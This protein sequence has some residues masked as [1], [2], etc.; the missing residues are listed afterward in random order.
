MFPPA[1]R[2]DPR[3]LLMDCRAHDS[4][5]AP[6]L[7]IGLAVEASGAP[8][9]TRELIG[10]LTQIKQFEVALC[11]QSAE[12]GEGMV[13]RRSSWLGEILLDRS[14]RQFD[15]FAPC[16]VN[17]PGITTT[18]GELDVVFCVTPKVPAVTT[19]FGI[20]SLQLGDR[21]IDPPYWGEVIAGD[22]LSRITLRWQANACTPARVVRT[23]DFPTRRGLGFTRNADNCLL[24]AAQMLAET[25][26]SIA[27]LGEEWLARVHS[28]PEADGLPVSRRPGNLECAVFAA[29]EV[30]RSMAKKGKP[31]PKGWFCAIRRDGARAYRR[32]GRFDGSGFEEMP[33][34]A[35]AQMAD[36]F[37][38]SENGRDWLF[39]EDVPP[40]TQKGRI[41][42]VEIPK[43]GQP[44][45]KAEV[46]LECETHLSYPC[47]FRHE[48]EF[49]MIPESCASQDLRLYRATKFP[50]EWQLETLLLENLPVT[51]TTPYFCGEHWYF[52]STT[53]PPV[54]QTVLLTSAKLGGRLRLHPSSPVSC[55]WRNTRAAGHI[56]TM[57]GRL[58]RPTQDCATDYGYGIQMN[59]VTRLSP[60]E[61]AERAADYIGPFWRRGLLGTHTLTASGDLEVIDGR[62]YLQ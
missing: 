60:S 54:Q 10:F 53:L 8:A 21:D 25:A 7:R 45:P 11:P 30:Y 28:L 58:I 4:G 31:R 35:G 16:S 52:F 29:R 5:T 2:Y 9:W 20:L 24:Y 36:P 61:Y 12:A 51:D 14:R 55:S 17:A 43:P 27:Y 46:V 57:N 26:L 1:V 38:V 13:A 39:Y 34:P 47:V 37:L 19:R 33:M 49:F 56:F 59:E 40:G 22:P 15:A 41:S 42:C 50:Y 18:D 32:L 6:R 3:R 48:G 44:W 23:A 62:R